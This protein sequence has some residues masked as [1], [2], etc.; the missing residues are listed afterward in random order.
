VR[1]VFSSYRSD[2]GHAMAQ[3]QVW[4][5]AHLMMLAAFMPLNIGAMLTSLR[6]T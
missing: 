3:Q 4:P 2:G 1:Q 5:P 6:V